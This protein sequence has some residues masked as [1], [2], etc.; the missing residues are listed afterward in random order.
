[1]CCLNTALRHLCIITTYMNFSIRL[2]YHLSVVEAYTGDN[3]NDNYIHFFFK[4]GGTDMPRRLRRGWLIR[5]ILQKLDFRVKLTG[6]IIDAVITKH[7]AELFTQKLE[8]LG[9]LTVYTKQ[10]DALMAEQSRAEFYLQDFVSTY[11]E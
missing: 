8:L 3:I 5:E 2:G 1:M 6:D 10:L 4:G 7:H 11:L 9:K